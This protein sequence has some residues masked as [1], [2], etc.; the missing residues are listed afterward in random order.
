MHFSF[1]ITAG[2]TLGTVFG[3][4]IQDEA[5]AAQP[6]AP[7]PQESYPGDD[8]GGPLQVGGTEITEAQI[9]RFL[10]YGPLRSAMEW[11]RINAI[12]EDEIGRRIAGYDDQL[13][14]WEAIKASGADPGPEPF[15]YTHEYFQIDDADFE[16]HYEDKMERFRRRYPTLNEANE[17]RRAYRSVEWYRRELRQEMYFDRCLV[18]DDTVHWPDLTFEAMRE[19]AGEIL[20]DDF[21]ESYE[22][23]KTQHQTATA[24]WQARVDAGEDAGPEPRLGQEDSM[25]RSILRQIVRDAVLGVTECKSSVDGLPP[26]LLCTMDFDWDGEPELALTVDEIWADV[27]RFVTRHEIDQA[28]RF[29]VLIEATRQR[30]EEEGHLITE[31][32]AAAHLEEIRGKF[33]SNIFGLGQMAVGAHQFPSVES[34]AAYMPLLESYRR[35]AEASIE[36]PPEGGLAPVLREHLP[37]ANQVMGLAKVD[38]EILLVA[39]LDMSDYRWMDDGWNIARKKAE[40]LKS[41]IEKNG[42]AY[43]DYRK[44]RMEAAAEGTPLE[45]DE[46]LMEPHDFWSRLLDEHCEFWDPPPP[47]EGRPG[48]DHAYKKL[49]R[50]GERTRNDMRSLLGESPYQNFLNGGLLTDAVY[51]KTPIGTV[52]GPLRGPHGWYLVK[53][54]KR[55]PPARPLNINDERHVEILKEDWARLTFI[56]YAHDALE[57]AEVTGLAPYGRPGTSK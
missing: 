41:E 4:P 36:S 3:L 26:E 21:K 46:D 49:G 25:Y 31:E 9:K 11:R 47:L 23:R 39:A 2:L 1:I 22:R 27:M 6:Q 34:Y 7:E 42:V 18:P 52:A 32:E 44:R 28:R 30:L 5:P 16:H 35:S 43:A 50:F 55:T 8:L 20:I 51:F 48:S 29:L 38:A 15:K 37:M 10:I 54:I 13:A 56:N 14:T 53:V 17:T 57:A 40:W 45:A 19:E 24:E 33:G 12:I